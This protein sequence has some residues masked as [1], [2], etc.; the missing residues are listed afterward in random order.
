MFQVIHS[1]RKN[2]KNFLFLTYKKTK[3][4]SSLCAFLLMNL[5]SSDDA[6]L[7]KHYWT[8]VQQLKTYFIQL[9]GF[10]YILL[11]IFPISASLSKQSRG[12]SP[13]SPCIELFFPCVTPF[14]FLWICMK[15]IKSIRK[16]FGVLFEIINV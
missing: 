10:G 13:K 2:I 16:T 7:G 4:N 14:F 5:V 3:K 9:S 15:T 6:G 11:Y 12:Y 8:E 1:S